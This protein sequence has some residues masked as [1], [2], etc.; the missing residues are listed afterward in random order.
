MTLG[1]ILGRHASETAG[2]GDAGCA[3]SRTQA[4]ATG[5]ACYLREHPLAVNTRPS[6]PGRRGDFGF[7]V[8]RRP[9][10]PVLP[11]A[12]G[13]TTRLSGLF[14]ICSLGCHPQGFDLRRWPG[15]FARGCLWVPRPMTLQL[16][17]GLTSSL[18]PERIRENG[19]R[20]CPVSAPPHASCALFADRS[21]HGAPPA[22][23]D[24]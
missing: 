10:S 20:Y 9:V 4:R 7:A 2:A 22:L 21:R 5:F 19:H 12:N 16:R 11:M 23:L 3:S 15:L 13:G 14:S 24:S 18:H 6:V 17:A 1:W 8:R